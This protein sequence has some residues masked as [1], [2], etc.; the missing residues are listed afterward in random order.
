MSEM[1]SLIPQAGAVLGRL[2][3]HADAATRALALSCSADGG[4]DARRL[5]Q[6]QLASYDLALASAELL[7]AE[8][9]LEDGS[10][11]SPLDRRLALTYAVDAVLSVGDKLQGILLNV[12]ADAAA[13]CM[14]CWAAPM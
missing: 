10:D 4:L 5:D 7:A 14:N 11:A 12:D 2:R 1:I 13:T 9:V 3:L 6:E 8:T